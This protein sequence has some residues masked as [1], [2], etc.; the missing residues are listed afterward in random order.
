MI[1]ALEAGSTAILLDED[2]CAANGMYRDAAMAALVA[3]DKEPLMPLTARIR[4]LAAAG[5]ASILAMG[6][7]SAY[8]G[9]ADTVVMM[10][11]Y[12]PSDVTA[13]A[14]AIA[15]HG[16]SSG[17]PTFTLPRPRPLPPALAA[18]GGGGG[19]APKVAVR[20]RGLV[21]FGDVD[22]DLGA[23]SQLVEKSQTRA[24]AAA[25]LLLR[26][27]ALR[28]GAGGRL[29]VPLALDALEAAL[30]A[31]GLDALGRGHHAAGDL[32]R[33]RR[34][35]IAAAFNRLRMSPVYGLLSA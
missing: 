21:S 24:V 35:E 29:T 16:P 15:G 10:D 23:V 11:C 6:G 34:L 22:L 19:G 1:E 20:S 4:S 7:S 33:P 31:G 18:S 2:T 14:H 30:D 8:F 3:P 5:V 9:E 28:P 32:A 25:L 12:A 27:W 26:S 17:A 13:R